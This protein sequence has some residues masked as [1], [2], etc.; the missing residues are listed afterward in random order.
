MYSSLVNYLSL[1]SGIWETLAILLFTTIRP[2]VLP[3]PPQRLLLSGLTPTGLS[4]DI[5]SIEENDDDLS[6]PSAL[7]APLPA[8]VALSEEEA[9][10]DW[11]R[12]CFI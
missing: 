6:A 2:G 1:R 10:Q 8:W 4:I 3:C 7:L 9:N 11:M 5:S 12:H